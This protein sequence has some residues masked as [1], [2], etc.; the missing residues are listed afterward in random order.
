MEIWQVKRSVTTGE[1]ALSYCLKW[2]AMRKYLFLGGG[3][4]G[5]SDISYYPL[6]SL[7]VFFTSLFDN[8]FFK[9]CAKCPIPTPLLIS[10]VSAN[11]LSWCYLDLMPV[12][13]RFV[14]SCTPAVH[15][16]VWYHFL[17]IKIKKDTDTVDVHVCVRVSVY[18]CMSVHVNDA[19]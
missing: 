9:F 15:V 4:G 8:H 19:R 11:V 3:R 17:K 12:G 16:S 2:I 6:F 1:M 7:A 5:G 10:P 14:A 18:V 13:G